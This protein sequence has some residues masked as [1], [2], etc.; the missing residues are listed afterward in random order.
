MSSMMV[1][2]L[3]ICVLERGWS[4]TRYGKFITRALSDA[5]LETRK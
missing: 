3:I 2:R 1:I 5:L 4:A